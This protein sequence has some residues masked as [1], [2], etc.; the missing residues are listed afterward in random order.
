M[1]RAP[2]VALPFDEAELRQRLASGVFDELFLPTP[3]WLP[4]GSRIRVQLKLGEDEQRLHAEAL[5]CKPGHLGEHIGFFLKLAALDVEA[6]ARLA[7]DDAGAAPEV[8]APSD[9]LL[10]DSEPPSTVAPVDAG[11]EREASTA[12]SSPEPTQ[13]CRPHRPDTSPSGRWYGGLQ[14]LD[15]FGNYQ[16]VER[17]GVGGMAEVYLA[18]AELRFGIDK[19]VAL[20]IVLPAF[21]PDTQH[22]SM[23]LTEARVSLTLQHPNLIQVF[24]FGEARGRTYLAMELVEGTTVERLLS[25]CRAN[26]MPPPLPFAVQLGIEVCRALEYV[27]EKCDLDGRRLGLVHR[28]V[29]SGNVMLTLGGQ[30]KLVDFGVVAQG[31]PSERVVVGKFGYM[32]PEQARGLPPHPSWDLYSLG[33]LLDELLTLRK[34]SATAEA[35]WARRRPAAMQVPPSAIISDIP[36]ILD[37]IVASATDFDPRRRPASSR[38]MRERLEQ[39]R[40][41]VGPCDLGV[42]VER[43]LGPELRRQK[44]ELEERVGRARRSS[45][46]AAGASAS[47]PVRRVRS[48]RRRIAATRTWGWLS[49][50]HRLLIAGALA[51]TVLLGSLGIAGHTL[52]V[53]RRV[54]ALVA[55]ADARFTA[56]RLVGPDDDNTLGLLLEAWSLRPADPR[57]SSRLAR[58][59]DTFEALAAAAER[60]GDLA[61][62]AVHLR[63]ALR[64][65]PTR[66]PLA[67]HAAQLERQVR[68]Q[69]PNVARRSP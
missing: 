55:R 26:G 50:G 5:V 39:A 29:S 41:L 7:C 62:A 32:P 64:A 3:Q 43:L 51:G 34:P 54:D 57:V 13:V 49:R 60:R 45:H 16:L 4:L 48:L 27:H 24:D 25:A 23:F 6:P 44:T 38:E 35:L 65:A 2:E 9:V 37:E 52:S 33:V 17:L 18:R 36:P 47:W 19:L 46:A 8:S 63:G 66:A 1:N 10:L 22:G 61:E 21:G 28:D 58:L 67:L 14:P 59:A 68:M 56:A 40:A 11:P 53:D 31:L 20:K 15:S 30:V 42:F 12:V 69:S